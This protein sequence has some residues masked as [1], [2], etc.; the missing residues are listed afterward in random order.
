MNFNRYIWDLFR[1]SNE[2][3]QVIKMFQNIDI[4]TLADQFGFDVVFE[5]YDEA[6]ILQSYNLY[7]EAVD[8]LR[9]KSVNSFEQARQLFSDEVIEKIQMEKF[10]WFIASIELYSTALFKTFPEYFFPYYFNSETY[11][12]FVTICE[13]LGIVLPP[14]PTRHDWVKRTWYYFEICETLHNFR[15][16]YGIEAT[17]FPALIY[18]FGLKNIEKLK[19]EDLPKPSRIYFLGGGAQGGKEDVNL[20]FKLLDNAQRNTTAVWGAG[21]LNI[22]KGDLV[23]M[24]CVSPRQYL[25]SIWRAIEDSF[26]DPFR[27][28]YY[29][30]KVGFPHRI[31][32]V[33]FHELRE[34][35]IFKE[36][37]TVKSQMQGMNGRPLTVKEYSEL[38]RMIEKKG[39]NTDSLPKLPVYNREIEH[40]ENEGDVEQ[41]LIEPLLKDLGFNESDWI[42]QL[43]LIMGRQTKYYPDYAIKA[44]AFRGKEKAQIVLEAK[45]SINSDKQLQEAFD[46]ARSYGLRLQSEKIVLADRDFVW[47]YGRTDDDFNSI[48]ILKMHWNELTDSDRLYKLKA[49]LK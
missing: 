21:N 49:L 41:Q 6:N 7:E 16:K 5:D 42:R 12:D 14:I 45:Y 43:P 44:N 36:N 20:D 37:A 33:S 28:H 3:I 8:F 19:E 35:H 40:I 48:P 30:I 18:G 26:I 1:N 9:N 23:L 24:Y 47:V 11:P 46:Q 4:N 34:N 15:K 13:N 38:L 27:F 17:E 10:N 29:C 22:K 2:G 39:Q 25:H 31:K 32:S